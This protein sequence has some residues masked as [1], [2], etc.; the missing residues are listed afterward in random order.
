MFARAPLQVG[1]L[2]FGC[3]ETDVRDAVR[4][5]VRML[6]E[7][8]MDAVKLEGGSFTG[9]GAGRYGGHVIGTGGDDVG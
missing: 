2:P 8:G 1:D 3:Y 6:K 9:V 5:A 4:S 7:G